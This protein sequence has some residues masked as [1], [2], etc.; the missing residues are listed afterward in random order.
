M[1]IY[2]EAGWGMKHEPV[3][4]IGNLID[5]TPVFYAKRAVG[6]HRRF[7][8]ELPHNTDSV[9]LFED[10]ATR[11]ARQSSEAVHN[12]LSDPM[13]AGLAAIS[14][15]ETYEEIYGEIVDWED[16]HDAS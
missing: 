1:Q 12:Q 3:A 7:L 11:R 6:N 5:G 9:I 8:K 2:E 16:Y 14:S 4:S 13:I 15:E 10:T